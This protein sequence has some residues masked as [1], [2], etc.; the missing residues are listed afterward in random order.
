VSNYYLNRIVKHDL[1]MSFKRAA[2]RWT[3][4]NNHVFVDEVS[5]FCKVISEAIRRGK[6]ILFLD[7]CSFNSNSFPNMAWAPIG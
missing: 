2:V 1:G 5:A 7:E 6:T 3:L 4:G